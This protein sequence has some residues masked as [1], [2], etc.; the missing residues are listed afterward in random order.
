MRTE[1]QGQVS[2]NDSRK[3]ITAHNRQIKKQ[4]FPV[5]TKP[6]NQP[7][8]KEGEAKEQVKE[9]ETKE[10][11]QNSRNHLSSLFTPKPSP[12][13]NRQHRRAVVG[14]PYRDGAFGGEIPDN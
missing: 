2:Y 14:T 10:M 6:E 11:D 9:E 8:K 1:P 7:I 4:K 12:I 3:A 13:P 5:S